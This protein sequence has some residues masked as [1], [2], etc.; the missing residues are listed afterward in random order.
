MLYLFLLNLLSCSAF[1]DSPTGVWLTQDGKA[2]IELYEENKN[3]FGKIV[4]LKEPKNT[5]GSEKVDTQNP[6][7]ALRSKPI[8]GLVVV[9]DLKP[10]GENKWNGGTIYDPEK[11]NVYKSKINLEKDVLK[12]RGFIGVSFLGETRT[13]T[14]SSL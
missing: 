8:I 9:K 7:A 5:D 11:G 13:W 6:D 3:I 4:W 10:D 2:K 14:R 12:L 1:A